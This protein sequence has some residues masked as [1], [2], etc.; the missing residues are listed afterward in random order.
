MALV[1]FFYKVVWISVY[2][3]GKAANGKAKKK[4]KSLGHDDLI[5]ISLY[6]RYS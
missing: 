5:W 6:C 1:P 2:V 4:K 3:L